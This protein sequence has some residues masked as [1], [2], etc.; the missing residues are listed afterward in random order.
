MQFTPDQVTDRSYTAETDAFMQEHGVTPRD[1]T[2]HPD[3]YPARV[4]DLARF[5]DAWDVWLYSEEHDAG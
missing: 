3:S 1:V 4:L 5:L 2:R